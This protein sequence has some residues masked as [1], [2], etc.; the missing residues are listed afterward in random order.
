MFREM[1]WWIEIHIL[2]GNNCFCALAGNF[3]REAVVH[4][5]RVETPRIRAFVLGYTES[6][7]SRLNQSVAI[8]RIEDPQIFIVNIFNG[9]SVEV[10]SVMECRAARVSTTE[11]AST[12]W[13]ETKR[14]DHAGYQ[15]PRSR[16]KLRL[17]KSN[18]ARLEPPRRPKGIRRNIPASPTL[19]RPPS[20]LLIGWTPSRKCSAPKI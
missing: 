18:P 10:I 13:L 12:P 15:L 7:C 17:H 9:E 8:K 6:N 2:S 20:L 5:L 1:K 16:S 11:D 19:Q 3:Y 14:K 4:G